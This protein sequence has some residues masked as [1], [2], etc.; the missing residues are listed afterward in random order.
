MP[1]YTYK[2]VVSKLEEV[3]KDNTEQNVYDVLGNVDFTKATLVVNADS[4]EE[5]E[6]IRKGLSD[7]RMWVVDSVEE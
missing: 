2:V 6:A 5:S 3:Y 7:I 1:K 4:E